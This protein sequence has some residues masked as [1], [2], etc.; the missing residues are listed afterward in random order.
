MEHR[1]KGGLSSKRQYALYLTAGVVALLTVPTD[2]GVAAAQTRSGGAT[3]TMTLEDVLTVDRVGGPAMSPDGRQVAYTLTERSLDE[4]RSQSDLWLIASLGDEWTASARLTST[5]FDESAPEWSPDGSR[6]GFL[7][8]ETGRSQ[9]WV[10]DPVT[11]TRRAVTEA[12]AGV[13]SFA[14]S[15]EGNHIA[16]VAADVPETSPDATRTVIVVEPRV[17]VWG[18]SWISAMHH[19]WVVGVDT[20]ETRRLTEGTDFSASDPSWSPDGRRMAYVRRP[21]P[22]PYSNYPNDYL[23]DIWVLDVED[24]SSRRLTDNPGPD[25]DPAWSPDGG[26]IAY[27]ARDGD[28]PIIGL[29]YLHLIPATGGPPRSIAPAF[30]G[31]IARFAWSAGGEAI[32]VS[33]GVGLDD[34]VYAIDPDSGRVEARLTGAGTGTAFSTSDRGRLAIVR[35]DGS[36]PGDVHVGELG[37]PPATSRAP[38]VLRRVS[39]HHGQ[40]KSWT[41]GAFED[42]RWTSTD[43]TEVEGLL[44][45]PVGDETGR[46][47]P[48]VVYAHGGPNGA[49]THAFPS[50]RNYG[51]WWAGQGWAVFYP[52]Y[53][54]STH[55]GDEFL[56][57]NVRD[58]GGGDFQDIMTG[59]DHLVATGVADPER[60][61]IAGWSFG[62]Y[63]TA[64]AI[65]QTDR[66]KAASYGAG[67]YNMVSM[68]GNSGIQLLLEAYLGYPWDNEDLYLAR[69][70]SHHATSIRTPTLILQGEEDKSVP[71]SQAQELYMALQKRGIPTRLVLFPRADHGLVEPRQQLEKMRRE[72]QWIMRFVPEVESTR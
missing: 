52:N 14:W 16:Y 34:R 59:V 8:R 27:L 62:G 40:V 15:P 26:R 30:E 54:G 13:R 42:V 12:P 7:S 28:S 61:A 36:H 63:M 66:F 60:L 18:R 38:V 51:H 19:L 11:H 72:S 32:V 24:G 6:L 10:M 43:G 71:V 57:A 1:T 55:Y 20:G 22:E 9:V 33:A 37:H 17:E 25:R 46:L 3:R 45:K 2:P 50:W 31:S 56:R 67:T 21:T 68:Y 64:W 58:W 53:R 49:Y 48:M 47:Y 23:T 35:G 65:S 69:S 4:N 5:A 29:L 41:L 44:L 70:A 39:D